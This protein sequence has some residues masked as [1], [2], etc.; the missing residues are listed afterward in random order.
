[1]NYLKQIYYEMRHHRMMTWVSISGTAL[2]I[3]LVMTF[4]MAER[5][6][7]VEM[8]PESNRSRIMSGTNLHLES[9]TNAF[10]G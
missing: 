4:V 10:L 3:F 7:T 9:N 2:A 5:I 6:N 1:M 8:A